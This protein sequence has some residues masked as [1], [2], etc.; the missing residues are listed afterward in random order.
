MTNQE[1]QDNFKVGDY[2]FLKFDKP[3]L[4][5]QLHGKI[6]YID[7][8]GAI[9]FKDNDSKLFLVL[10]EHIVSFELKEMLERPTEHKGKPI[11]Y[12]GGR[13]YYKD[14]N[15]ECDISR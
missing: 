13:F 12:N 1:I 10:P 8:C 15:K 11:Y 14:S 5:K 9:V 2:G 6:K 4:R 3:K 7:S